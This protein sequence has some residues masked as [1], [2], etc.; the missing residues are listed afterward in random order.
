MFSKIKSKFQ[1]WLCG[2]S[3]CK[4]KC[5]SGCKKLVCT[6]CKTCVFVGGGNTCLKCLSKKYQK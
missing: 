3:Q 5:C 2:N 6:D 1:C 4:L